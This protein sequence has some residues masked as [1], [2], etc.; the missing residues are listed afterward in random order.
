MFK[1]WSSLPC[2]EWIIGG[3]SGKHRNYKE[4]LQPRG[5]R[6][7]GGWLQ[8]WVGM[9]KFAAG[10]SS[11]PPKSHTGMVN[12]SIVCLQC[13]TTVI[14]LENVYVYQNAVV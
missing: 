4:A 14:I 8:E 12:S 6:E 7:K 3:Q 5:K 13:I 9:R 10:L 11:F 1:R 2:G